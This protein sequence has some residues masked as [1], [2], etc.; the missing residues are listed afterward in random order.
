MEDF[1]QSDS[2]NQLN[3]PEDAG[4]NSEKN[5]GKT[6]EDFFDSYTEDHEHRWQQA[7]GKTLVISSMALTGATLYE[8]V[9]GSK[10]PDLSAYS[11]V[12]PDVVEQAYQIFRD[13]PMYVHGST[14]SAAATLGTYLV[15]KRYTYTK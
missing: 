12:I 10:L 14:A 7:L 3:I 6:P 2:E 9:T 4:E 13:L 8:L 15:R 11:D 5:E 1:P